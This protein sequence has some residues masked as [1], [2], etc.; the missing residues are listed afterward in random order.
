MPAGGWKE[1]AWGAGHRAP[2]DSGQWGLLPNIPTAI[3]SRWVAPRKN[4]DC[5]RLVVPVLAMTVWPLVRPRPLAVPIGPMSKDIAQS[6]SAAWSGVSTSRWVIFAGMT[7]PV[8]VT[9][10]L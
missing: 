9:I 10:S 2:G 4:A 6:T 5:D 7:W 8:P 1:R 3:A